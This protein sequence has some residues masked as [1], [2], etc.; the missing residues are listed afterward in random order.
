[1]LEYM[2]KANFKMCAERMASVFCKMQQGPW[3][4]KLQSSCKNIY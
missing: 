2:H 4:L 3:G 1:M